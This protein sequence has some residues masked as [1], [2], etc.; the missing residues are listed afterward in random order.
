MIGEELLSRMHSQWFLRQEVPTVLS[1]VGMNGWWRTESHVAIF[2]QRP[3]GSLMGL[4]RSIKMV[5]TTTSP[6][7]TP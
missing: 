7:K 3:P 2:A 4:Q 5:E 6:A 1:S